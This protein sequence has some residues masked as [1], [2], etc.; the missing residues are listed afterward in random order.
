[1]LLE[2]SNNRSGKKTK[3]K[4]QYTHEFFQVAFDKE[5]LSKKKS[6]SFNL[7]KAIFFDTIEPDVFFKFILL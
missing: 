1:M 4:I 2:H 6:K 7:R 3:R 5:L